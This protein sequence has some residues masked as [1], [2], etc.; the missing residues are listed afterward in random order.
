MLDSKMID[1]FPNITVKIFII[2]LIANCEA[3]RLFSVLKRIKRVIIDQLCLM[4]T[5]L[6]GKI[7]Y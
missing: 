1:A 3:E 7:G 4:I 5:K 2:M 6:L